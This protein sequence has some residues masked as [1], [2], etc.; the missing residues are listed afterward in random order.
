MDSA[1]LIVL[2]VVFIVAQFIHARIVITAIEEAERRIIE[3]LNTPIDEDP[4]AWI[5]ADDLPL[6]ER[7]FG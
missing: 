1:N 3:E 4:P 2:G 5:P 7:D 6:D